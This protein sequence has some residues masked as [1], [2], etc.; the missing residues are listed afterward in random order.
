MSQSSPGIA[1]G[2]GRGGVLEGQ[3][4]CD[5]GPCL[6]HARIVVVSTLV[7]DLALTIMLTGMPGESKLWQDYPW[8]HPSL[9][10]CRL[11]ML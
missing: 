5:H 9:P 2:G 10:A 1:A 11:S 6:Q 3:I 4:V 8:T 7:R